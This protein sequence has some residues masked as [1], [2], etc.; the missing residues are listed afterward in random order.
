MAGSNTKVDYEKWTKKEYLNLIKL[1][2]SEGKSKDKIAKLMGMSNTSFRKLM[3]MSKAF[4]D[5]FTVTFDEVNG[6]V[7]DSL[8]KRAMGFSAKIT[9]TKTEV[10]GTKEEIENI[11]KVGNTTKIKQTTSTEEIYFPPDTSAIIFWLTNK[12]P[13]E[14]Q[15]RKSTDSKIEIVDD[16][17]IETI[18]KASKDI[19]DNKDLSEIVEE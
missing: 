6:L 14:W 1:W 18:Q 2:V 11:N 4:A 17:I 16:G 9:K 8:L 3:D 7:K 5:C 12:L 10:V 19:Y 15:N 13:N